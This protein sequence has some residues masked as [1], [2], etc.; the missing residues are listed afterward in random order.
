VLGKYT[1]EEAMK[2]SERAVNRQIITEFDFAA[3]IT[4]KQISY[5]ETPGG[6]RVSALITALER[7]DIQSEIN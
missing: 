4:G 2:I 1:V 7:I 3:D 5:E 6:L